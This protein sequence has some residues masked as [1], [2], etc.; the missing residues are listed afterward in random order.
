[1]LIIEIALGVF[2]GGLLLWWLYTYNQRK[3]I[4]NQNKLE[5]DRLLSDFTDHFPICKLQYNGYI[6]IFKTRLETLEDE[7]NLH[8][9]DAGVI[10]LNL[11]N[12]KLAELKEQIRDEMQNIVKSK[13]ANAATELIM[14]KLLDDF[15]TAYTLEVENTAMAMMIDKVKRINDINTEKNNHLT[16]S[17]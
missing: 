8:F 7:A 13:Y 12:E 4:D 11:F 6:D 16:Q 2:I 17:N 10:E 15:L 1:M 9:Y 5:Q 3:K 14:N